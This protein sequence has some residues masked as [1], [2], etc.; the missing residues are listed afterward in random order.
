VGYTASI[1]DFL[2]GSAALPE[3]VFIPQPGTKKWHEKTETMLKMAFID[4]D[5]G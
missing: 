3:K 1:K 5:V 2:P 4:T